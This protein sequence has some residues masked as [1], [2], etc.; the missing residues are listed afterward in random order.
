MTYNKR[1][2]PYIKG[3]GTPRRRSSFVGSL[4]KVLLPLVLLTSAL[5]CA[6]MNLEAER[7][8]IPKT[9]EP[10]ISDKKIHRHV[11]V[12]PH[13][14]DCENINYT[15]H[16]RKE[17]TREK[18]ND[19]I[20]NNLEY[21]VEYIGKGGGTVVINFVVDKE[22]NIVNPEIFHDKS[23][24][25]DAVMKTFKTMPRWI[26]GKHMGV[27]VDVEEYIRIDIDEK[28]Y[29][30]SDTAEPLK[31]DDGNF[32]AAEKMAYFT[33]CK[34]MTDAYKEACNK[35]YIVQYVNSKLLN[36]N[37]IEIKRGGGPIGSC[38]RYLSFV[39]DKEGNITN[40]KAQCRQEN[41]CTNEYV[42]NALKGMPK[43]IPAQHNGKSVDV[44]LIFPYTAHP[45]Y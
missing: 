11:E 6:D 9:S 31:S 3:K 24:F 29:L 25:G 13:F 1:Q 22:G 21:P 4:L 36:S 18:V 26:P 2:K 20:Y 5:M 44:E 10:K 41:A 7:K 35:K 19:F 37:T 40:I 17:C 28:Q 34:G 23:S 39:I 30:V 32:I 14:P 12:M 15:E 27:P 8:T 16:E 45:G 42:Q 43:W 33:D 38:H